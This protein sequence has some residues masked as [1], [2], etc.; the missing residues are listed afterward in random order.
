[1]AASTVKFLARMSKKFKS[2]RL[3]YCIL[4]RAKSWIFVDF[5]IFLN[6]LYFIFIYFTFILYTL[7]MT[8]MQVL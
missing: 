5:D 7:L 3:L 2:M 8:E 6:I 1:M 4:T